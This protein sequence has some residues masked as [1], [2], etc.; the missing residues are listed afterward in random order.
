MG[1]K[2]L[3]VSVQ[4]VDYPKCFDSLEEWEGWKQSARA[5]GEPCNIC[6]DC[7]NAYR[8]TM[9][10]AGRCDSKTWWGF[11]PKQRRQTDE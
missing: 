11:A 9:E 5:C 10:Q 6:H 3:K 7:T 2:A 4:G 8:Y 1:G